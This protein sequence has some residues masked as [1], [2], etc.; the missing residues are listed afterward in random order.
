MPQ[1]EDQG[2][3]A[4]HVGQEASPMEGRYRAGS[5][6]KRLGPGHPRATEPSKWSGPPSCSRRLA[7]SAAFRTAGP[8]R[9]LPLGA[10]RP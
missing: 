8:S 3:K 1:T 6:V 9:L 7:L 2:S 5:L 4:V 10:R